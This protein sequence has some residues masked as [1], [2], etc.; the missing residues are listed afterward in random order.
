MIKK[1]TLLF[2][3]FYGC[4]LSMVQSQDY[5]TGYF[6]D[7]EEQAINGFIDFTYSPKKKTTMEV[8]LGEIYTPGH[9][10]NLQGQKITGL[11]KYNQNNNFFRFTT[12]DESS[13]EKIKPDECNGYV[14]GND[15]FAVINN[16]MVERAIGGFEN[17]EPDF[18]EVITTI[19]HLTFYEHI[20]IGQNNIVHTFMV[21]KTG[22]PLV[23]FPQGSE[24]FKIIALE[25]FGDVP[26]LRRKIDEGEYDSDDM[27]PLIKYLEFYKRYEKKEK[28]FYT[29]SWEETEDTSRFVYYSEIRK[30]A[31]SLWTLA[32]FQKDGAPLYQGSYSSLAP[33]NKDGLFT[34]Y[35][36]D[37]SKRKIIAY[38]DNEVQDSILEYYPNGQL[39]YQYFQKK[40]KQSYSKVYTASGDQQLDPSGNGTETFYDSIRNRQITRVYKSNKL[41][42]S[43]Y[44]DDK[45][46]KVC[47]SGKGAGALIAV[48][49]MDL[50]LQYPSRSIS[51]NNHGLVLARVLADEAGITTAISLV[52]G[53]DNSC[54]QQVLSYCQNLYKNGKAWMPVKIDKQPVKQEILV[55][56]VFEIKGYSRYRNNY[57][58]NNM[59]MQQQQMMQQQMMMQ[60]MQRMAAPR[61]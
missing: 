51:Q 28:T 17:T 35:Y 30:V 6:T 26:Y 24:K 12:K 27:Y 22:G 42:L 2:I 53:I 23:S 56:F 1:I 38:R 49:P 3:L 34:F 41:D 15:S 16:F 33:M 48:A 5:K 21:R 45:G 57:Y 59:W 4:T 32:Y 25:Y 31:G 54:D 36:P 61:F 10:Y 46:A 40:S 55:P 7:S 19:D 50:K 52:K 14:M 13:S 47:Q 37:G 29:S 43:Y 18:A 11:L 20:R 9:Y 8:T 60:N 58:Y 44:I 39:H